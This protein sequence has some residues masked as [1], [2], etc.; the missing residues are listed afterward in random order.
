MN[1]GA[2][3]D[4]GMAFLVLA[5]QLFLFGFFTSSMLLAFSLNRSLHE[6]KYSGVVVGFTNMLVIVG[7]AVFQPMV[8]AIL[9]LRQALTGR[10]IF[11]FTV[12]DYQ[13]AL[14]MLPV[15]QMLALVILLV[16]HKAMKE[17]NY[18]STA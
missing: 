4:R 17:I 16:N 1:F 18:G 9:D 6:D 3:K 11:S 15:C 5:M 13:T 8:G 2:K 10:N 7:S 12:S 14:I